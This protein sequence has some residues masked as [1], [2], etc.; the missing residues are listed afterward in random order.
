MKPDLVVQTIE[1]LI[2]LESSWKELEGPS[3]RKLLAWVGKNSLFR[4]QYCETLIGISGCETI[5]LVLVMIF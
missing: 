4:Y 1:T 5:G 2:W 3:L